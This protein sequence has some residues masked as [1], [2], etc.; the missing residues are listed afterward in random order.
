LSC[1]A[2]V[3]TSDLYYYYYEEYY[4]DHTAASDVTTAAPHDNAIKQLVQQVGVKMKGEGQIPREQL[5]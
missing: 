3:V 5:K 1:G 4:D 2:A